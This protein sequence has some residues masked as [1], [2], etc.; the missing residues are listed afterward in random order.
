[1]QISVVR[2]VTQQS[3]AWKDDEGVS[4]KQDSRQLMP[5]LVVTFLQDF[6]DEDYDEPGEPFCDVMYTGGYLPPEFLRILSYL[7]YK[8]LPDDCKSTSKNVAAF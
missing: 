7:S 2:N 6:Y 3:A 1:M 4:R 8:I 5:T